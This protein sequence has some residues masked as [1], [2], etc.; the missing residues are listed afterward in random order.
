MANPNL[1]QVNVQ[2][3][4]TFPHQ[5]NITYSTESPG[6]PNEKMEAVAPSPQDPS[7]ANSEPQEMTVDLKNFRRPGEKTFTQRCRLFVG[8]LPTD[9]TDEDFKK[10]F[11]KYGDA[12]EVFINRDRGFGFIRLVR[13]RAKH[14]W[15]Q[16]QN[17]AHFTEY[18]YWW[19]GVYCLKLKQTNKL[20]NKTYLNC[21]SFVFL[22]FI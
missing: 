4:A 17:M 14:E 5:Q 20:P 12:K 16:N 15:H 10:I 3:N 7:S 19:M 13:H 9:M 1:K 6:D 21:V 22:S 18:R 11:F 2:N 8:N